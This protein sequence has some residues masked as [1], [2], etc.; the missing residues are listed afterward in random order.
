MLATSRQPGIR[1]VQRV[2]KPED[3]TIKGVLSWQAKGFQYSRVFAYIMHIWLTELVKGQA[4]VR[5]GAWRYIDKGAAGE[6]DRQAIASG[7]QDLE[8]RFSA[9]EWPLA[10]LPYTAINNVQVGS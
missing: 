2:H 7:N 6:I 5:D 3:E 10:I 8:I 1:I 9:I 4:Q